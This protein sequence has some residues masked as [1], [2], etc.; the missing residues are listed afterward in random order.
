LQI[1]KFSALSQDG[2]RLYVALAGVTL[3]LIEAGQA[4]EEKNGENCDGFWVEHP[5]DN[6]F[7]LSAAEPHIG[8]GHFERLLVNTQACEEPEMR[9]L[10]AMHEG[11]FPFVRDLC[12][13]RFLLVHTGGSQTG[14]TTGAQRFTELHGLGSVKGDF[15][16]AAL[17]NTGDIGLL[18][19]DN[20][21]QRDLS[22]D[23]INSLLFLSTGGERGRS[24]KD[25]RMRPTDS[26]RPVGVITSIEGLGVK[27]ELRKR[28]IEV[29]YV[30]TGGLKRGEIEREIRQYRNSIN[31]AIA[32]VLQ[33]FFLIASENTPNPILEFAEHFNVLCNLLRAYGFVAGKPAEWAEEIIEMWS[34]ILAREGEGEGDILEYAID[35]LLRR[36]P[37][38]DRD[39]RVISGLYGG[40]SGKFYVT[41][42]GPLLARLLASDSPGKNSVP[43]TPEGLSRRLRGMTS[44][45]FKVLNEKTAPQI[46]FLKRTTNRRPIGFFVVDDANDG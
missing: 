41:E 33:Y 7:G 21:E 30:G 19:M 4:S 8:L 37:S 6:P 34:Q 42:C 38:N 18:V 23:Y 1:R 3:L 2:K 40:K 39:F 13:A 32:E 14:K 10:V 45:K 24:Y 20:K 46:P 31:T 26:G 12:P 35:W 22:Q 11:L 9:W 36:W 5:Y 43:P 15:S 28:C 29:R 44:L 25:G 27:P 16:V 17:G